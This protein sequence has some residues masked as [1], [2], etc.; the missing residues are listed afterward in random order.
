M[1]LAARLHLAADDQIALVQV[2]NEHGMYVR[3]TL[4][5]QPGARLEMTVDL[6]DGPLRATVVVRTAG[7]SVEGYG[8]GVELHEI[9]G[10]DRNRWRRNYAMELSRQKLVR[11]NFDEAYL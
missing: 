11:S 3:P 5:L 8:V 9:S 10:G 7:D 1:I 6:V 4:A 2:I